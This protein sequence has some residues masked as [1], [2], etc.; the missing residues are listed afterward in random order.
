MLWVSRL[1]LPAIAYL[2]G[3]VLY[4]LWSDHLYAGSHVGDLIGGLALGVVLV[5]VLVLTLTSWCFSEK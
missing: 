2:L 1:A 4:W 3:Q 5:L